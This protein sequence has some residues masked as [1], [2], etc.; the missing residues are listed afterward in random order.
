M[1]GWAIELAP[2]LCLLYSGSNHITLCT[3]EV[4]TLSHTLSHANAH[5]L[6]RPLAHARMATSS[7]TAMVV[8]GSAT[9]RRTGSPSCSPSD[10][11][12]T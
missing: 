6:T 10:S 1:G 12:S 11:R 4:Y 5:T 9:L 7:S 8:L 3:S 2:L